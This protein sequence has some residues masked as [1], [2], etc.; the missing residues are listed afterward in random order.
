MTYDHISGFPQFIFQTQAAVPAPPQ[1]SYL[2][3]APM[4]LMNNAPVGVP[5]TTLRGFSPG[6]QLAG[7]SAHYTKASPSASESST[8]TCPYPA[9]SN[10]TW[11]RK[12]E[13]E[14]HVLTH[15]P[16]HIYCPHRRCGWTGSRRYA[17]KEH[18][19]KKHP[20]GPVLPSQEAFIIYDAKLLAKRV[21]NGEITLVEAID[22]AQT[23]VRKK[24]AAHAKHFV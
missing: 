23:L 11:G 14:R 3:E 4:M 7:A 15:L 21:V 6:T 17:L 2:N 8:G 24:T 1:G 12:Q 9:C 10:G 16:N 18:Y 19:E 20:D 5:E 13:L 22:E